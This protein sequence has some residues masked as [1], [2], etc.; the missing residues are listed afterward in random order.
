VKFKVL[1]MVLAL[2]FSLDGLV[3]G[4][5]WPD[6]RGPNRDGTWQEKGVKKNFD[7]E[8]IKEKWRIPISSGYSGPSVAE[9]RV[10]ITDRITNPKE[11]ERVM[12]F[13]AMTGEKIWSHSYDCEYRGIGYTAGPR[14]S[15]VIDGDRAYSLGAMGHLFCFQSKTGKV[16]WSKDLDEEYDIRMPTWGIAAA[17][18]IVDDKLVLCIGG[19]N[20]ACIVTLN[21]LTGEEIWRNLNDDAS[22]SAPILIKQD[23]K[24]VVVIWTGQ[25][26]VGLNPDTGFLYWQQGFEQKKMV[27]NIS[28]PVFYNNFLF[29]SSFFDGSMLL[30]LDTAKPA[31]EKVW[32]RGGKNEKDTDAIHCCISTPLLKGNFIY[33][34]DSYG[35]LRC[36]NLMNGDRIW[37][38]LTA[39]KSA[40]WANIHFVQNGEVTYMFNEQGELIIAKL[41]PEGFDEIS[42]ARLIEPTEEQ[43]SRN[44]SGVTW[45]HPAFAYKHVFIRNDEALLCADLTTK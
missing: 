3:F 17:P 35:E 7:S 25:R 2:Y 45:A 23:N 27:I 1:G 21:K 42:R 32:Q 34:V 24:P 31:A 18:L 38:D 14:A 28:S 44:G 9:G 37:E 16:L 15:V 26:V 20:N 19:E 39:V 30:K 33:G 10:Y 5:E 29:V 11:I 22:Y 8:K 13:D 6:W 40:R 4:D 43:L 12:C 41:S 36:L